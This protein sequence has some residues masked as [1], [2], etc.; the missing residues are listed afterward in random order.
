MNQQRSD[1]TN[2]RK[3]DN[4]AKVFPATANKKNTKVF[5]FYCELYEE[6]EPVFLQEAMELTLE[7]YPL[8]KSVL[9]RGIFWFYL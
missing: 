3:L 1:N 9:R 6:V 2:W 7:K 5:R 4:A 8:F